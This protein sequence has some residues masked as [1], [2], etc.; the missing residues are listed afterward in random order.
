[1]NFDQNVFQKPKFRSKIVNYLFQKKNRTRL[2]EE[3]FA[4]MADDVKAA[5]IEP[6]PNEDN[7]LKK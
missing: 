6:A 2:E 3:R 5:W 4:A 7:L 1:M